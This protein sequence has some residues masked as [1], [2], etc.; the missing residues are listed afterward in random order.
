V[1]EMRKQNLSI[2]DI[3]L[4]LQ[5]RDRHLST[6]YNIATNQMVVAIEGANNDVWMT[7]QTLGAKEWA[8]WTDTGVPCFGPPALVSTPSSVLVTE[9]F[10][11]ADGDYG[12]ALY[13]S[14][15]NIIQTSDDRPA[16]TLG[17]PVNN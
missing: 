11:D 3:S 1:I 6:T 10:S 4:A 2:Y 9:A 16:S 5:E 12:L 14:G 8:N 7:S 15:G 13:N 17:A